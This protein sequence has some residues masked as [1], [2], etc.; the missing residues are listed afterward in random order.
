MGL[1]SAAI[2]F[3]SGKSKDEYLSGI[4]NL[5]FFLVVLSIPISFIFSPINGFGS[6]LFVL[7]VMLKL[8][9]ITSANMMIADGNNHFLMAYILVPPVLTVLLVA[10]LSLA[11]GTVPCTPCN[12]AWKEDL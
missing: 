9:T 7:L 10:I 2:Y 5:S 1:A 3:L 8:L 6:G 11:G 4:L 12:L